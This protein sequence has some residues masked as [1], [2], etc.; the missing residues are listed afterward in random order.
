MGAAGEGQM[1]AHQA[2]KLGHDA[3]KA[4]RDRFQ[5][6]IS[7]A[8]LDT[9]PFLRFAEGS[10][11]MNYLREHRAALGGYL[12]ARRRKS[13]PLTFP[14]FPASTR[15]ESDRRG[16]RN[17]DHDGLRPDSDALLRDKIWASMLSRS[18]PT[19]AAPS[20]WRAC[21]GRWASSARSASSIGPRTPTS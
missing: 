13:E 14:R 12:P 11:E 1:I 18:F 16:P 7:D 17:L 3:L 15:S 6:P 5:I 2:K 10:E 21:F 9:V 19:R 20:A 4:F 8:D